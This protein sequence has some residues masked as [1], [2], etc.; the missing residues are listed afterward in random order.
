[1][2][3]SYSG[4]EKSTNQPSYPQDFDIT[5]VFFDHEFYWILLGLTD[6]YNNGKTVSGGT[7]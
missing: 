5:W 4:W 6:V 3:Y 1:M 7:S 2:L